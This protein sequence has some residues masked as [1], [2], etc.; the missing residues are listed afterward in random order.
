MRNVAYSKTIRLSSVHALTV[1]ILLA[2]LPA[3]AADILRIYQI[4]VEGGGALLIVTPSG[5]SMLIDSGSPPPASGERDSKR[6]AAAMQAA[7]LTKINY[8]FITHYD[9]DHVGGAVSANN[10]AHFDR[11]FD[12]GD[13]DMNY[14]QGAGIE[15]RFKAYLSV[16]SNKRTIVKPGDT[17]PLAGVQVQVV[18]GAGEVLKSPINGGGGPNPFCEGAEQHA[19]DKSENSRSAGILLTYGWFTFLDLGD[20]TWD[21]EM[22]L[23]CPE[24]KLGKVTLYL[25]THHGF[26]G[27]I[28]GAPAH[29]WAVDPQVVIVNNGP[30]KALGQPAY[31]RIA[32]IP[33]LEGLWQSH[34][35][36]A[37]D[38]AHNTAPDMIANMEDS[39]D[40]HG[41][42]IDVEVSKNGDTFTVINTRNKF[43]KTY[44][45]RREFA[46]PD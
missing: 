29:V 44:K 7:G 19:P 20:L 27:D 15:D 14:S 10:V 43:T 17:I 40:C 35:A 36:L 33:G 46:H 1:A 8:L 30:R 5:Q 23:A 26:Y 9:G 13:P 3:F 34:L 41:N 11:F 25:A 32:K 31:E 45:T 2:A 22:A 28:S 37:N 12:H 18:S 39:N 24:N 38:A 16:A 4:D 6:I 42:P 21:K